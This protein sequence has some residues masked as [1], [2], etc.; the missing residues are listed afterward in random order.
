MQDSRGILRRYGIL[1]VQQLFYKAHAVAGE[2]DLAGFLGGIEVHVGPD[3]KVMIV[4]GVADR[5]FIERA[6][7][8][9]STSS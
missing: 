5:Y 8:S 4:V 7:I 3:A 1:L 9:V 2:H 6:S